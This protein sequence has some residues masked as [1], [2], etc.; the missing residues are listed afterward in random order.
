MRI[1][2]VGPQ[3]IPPSVPNKVEP[4]GDGS[5]GTTIKNAIS[6]VNKLQGKADQMAT[7]LASGDAIEVH[8]AMI[9]MQQASQA[10]NLTIQVRNKVIEAYQE[11]MKTQV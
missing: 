2:G 1:Q 4:S 9:A 3:I 5:F 11:V 8:Q 6:D 7:Q 10:L